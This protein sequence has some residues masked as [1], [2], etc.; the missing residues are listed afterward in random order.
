MSQ[1]VVQDSFYSECV[2]QDI[3]CAYLEVEAEF[4]EFNF[5]FYFW[6]IFV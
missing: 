4:I 5:G 2:V 1:Q 6:K 3:H